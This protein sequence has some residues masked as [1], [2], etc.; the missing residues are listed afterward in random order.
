LC[1]SGCPLGAFLGLQIGALTQA[2]AGPECVLVLMPIGQSAP[3]PTPATAISNMSA[4][5]LQTEV[6]HLLIRLA[7]YNLPIRL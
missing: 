4:E 6:F 5:K 3:G 1:R 7:S 2:A